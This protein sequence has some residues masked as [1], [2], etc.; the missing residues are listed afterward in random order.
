MSFRHR[1]GKSFKKLDQ[2]R[3]KA[4]NQKGSTKIA[5]V[6]DS[7][8]RRQC[9]TQQKMCSDS[10]FFFYLLIFSGTGLKFAY[11]DFFCLACDV[12]ALSLSSLASKPQRFSISRAESVQNDSP[13]E[14]FMINFFN[15][16]KSSKNDPASRY[17]LLD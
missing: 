12:V 5:D 13:K 15:R 10:R 11:L 2:T 9:S 8:R 17:S 6:V 16:T 14:I 3:R 4:I 7:E 1:F